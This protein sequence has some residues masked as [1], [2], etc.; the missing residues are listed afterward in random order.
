MSFDNKNEKQLN[1]NQIKGIVTEINAGEIFSSIT[2]S[3]G[4]ETKR[5]IN[6]VFKSTL[7]ESITEKIKIEDKVIVKFYLA[8]YNK[9]EKWKTLAHL[10]FIDK[11]PTIA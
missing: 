7:L 3:V 10:L 1:F 9:F 4:H 6:V 5:Y 11:L 2:L 8:S